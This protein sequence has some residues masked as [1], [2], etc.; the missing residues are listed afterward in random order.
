[1]AKSKA[2]TICYHLASITDTA[3]KLASLE[4]PYRLYR[5]LGVDCG[6]K[7]TAA[8]LRRAFHKR[9]LKLHPDKGGDADSFAELRVAYEN[10]SD[11]RRRTAYDRGAA[12]RRMLVHEE[13]LC[14]LLCV[15]DEPLAVLLYL[16]YG[17]CGSADKTSGNGDCLCMRRSLV[18]NKNA[19]KAAVLVLELNLR[20]LEGPLLALGL[21]VSSCIFMVASQEAVKLASKELAESGSQLVIVD[22][23]ATSESI[24]EKLTACIAGMVPRLMDGAQ[25]NGRVLSSLLRSYT[26]SFNKVGE[27]R[28]SKSAMVSAIKIEC[29]SV[30][31]RCVKVRA[32]V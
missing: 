8:E 4:E 20:S 11:A 14:S 29:Q 6:P 27:V 23:S 31:L 13:A 12:N 16:S 2:A 19:S 30:C 28:Y 15:T 21:L 5:L 1:M 32:G 7:S 24:E 3:V 26:S 18:T 10:L 22:E 17:K 25:I 9:S